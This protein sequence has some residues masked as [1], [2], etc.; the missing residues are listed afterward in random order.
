MFRDVSTK[1]RQPVLENG[2]ICFITGI[3]GT[4]ARSIPTPPKFLEIYTY[5]IPKY[6]QT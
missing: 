2:D 4:V 1:R 5:K 3:G 6:Q